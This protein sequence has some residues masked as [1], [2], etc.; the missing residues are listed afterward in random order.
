MSKRVKMITRMGGQDVPLGECH[1]GQARV[2]VREEM[3]AWQ[4]GKLLL[5]LRPWD[6]ENL[7]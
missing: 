7:L 2:L 1:P 3:A 6:L 5:V 4:D